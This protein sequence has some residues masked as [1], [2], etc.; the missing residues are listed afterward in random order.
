MNSLNQDL[1]LLIRFALNHDLLKESDRTWAANHL[2]Q[3]FGQSSFEVDEGS[4]PLP[5]TA[6]PILERLLDKAVGLGLIEDGQSR[7]DLF[8]TL[9]M[10]CLTPRPAEVI[11][12]FR[13][14]ESNPRAATDYF[15]KLNVA[16][17]YV[18]KS[19]T[20]K[21]I[22]WVTATDYG[23]LNI[24]INVSKPEKDPKEIAAAKSAPS[25]GYPACLLCKENEGFFGNLNHP[26][27]QNLRLVPL[28]L[29]GEKWYLQYS[30]LSLTAIGR[31]RRR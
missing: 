20:D 14:L 27:R 11:R 2:I 26:A 13:E 31:C 15:Y 5:E 8:D 7:R 16:S 6:A 19:R 12:R 21:N 30:P 24:T 10:D 9:I 4:E 25:T 18:R 29:G 23:D 1:N 17:N 3:L 28:E 22:S